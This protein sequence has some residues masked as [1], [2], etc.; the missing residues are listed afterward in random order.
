MCRFVEYTYKVKLAKV[1]LPSFRRSAV[2]NK[3]SPGKIGFYRQF[4]AIKNRGHMTA[5]RSGVTYYDTLY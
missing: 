3:N 5:L 2:A 1:Q 4:F